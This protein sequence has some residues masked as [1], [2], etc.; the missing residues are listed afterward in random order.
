MQGILT[1]LKEGNTDIPRF[2]AQADALWA[3]L[4][5]DVDHISVAD[6][7]E[8]L[9]VNQ[10]RFEAICG[11]RS[12]GKKVMGLSGISHFYSKGDGWRDGD[13]RRAY[14]LSQ[15]F[16]ESMCSGEVKAAAREAA[17]VYAVEDHA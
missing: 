11:Q 10:S 12:M 2:F 7:A 16:A 14:K 9:N 6:L 1:E 8:R 13:G 4:L 3:E 15:A 17:A 5:E